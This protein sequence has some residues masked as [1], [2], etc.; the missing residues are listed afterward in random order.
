MSEQPATSGRGRGG[1]SNRRSANKG[2]G[3]G[4]R[5]GGRGGTP[6][7]KKENNVDGVAVAEKIQNLTVSDKQ[8]TKGGRG[9]G[10]GRGGGGSKSNS[11][12]RKRVPANSKDK[13]MSEDEI[14]RQQDEVK[15]REQKVIEEAERKRLEEE[16][17][18]DEAMKAAKQKQR[19]DLLQKVQD[20]IVSLESVVTT[21]LAHKKNRENLCAENLVKA[22]CEFEQAK[23]SLKSDLKK[24]TAFVKKVKTGAAWS[25]KPSDVE[26]DIG[27]L[28]LS[29]YVEEVA[30]AVLEAKL[31]LGDLPVVIELCVAMHTRYADFLPN[32]VPNMWIIIH[33]KPTEETAKLRRIYVRLMT[34]FLLNGI[35][36]ETKQLLKLVGE[37][38]GGSAGTYAVSDA[39][40]MVSF[41]KAAA[42]E[43]LGG[44]P[45]SIRQEATILATELRKLETVERDEIPIIITDELAARAKATLDAVDEVLQLRAV[46][47][48]ITEVFSAHCTGA[49]QSL[50]KSLVT[51]HAKLQKLEKRCDQDR[52]LQGS[53]SD[54][55]DK[56][57]ADA[58]KLQ[59]SLLKSVETLSD[60]LD[61]VAPVL[62]DEK[63]EEHEVGQ[64]IELW[65]K[66]D[67]GGDD[68]LGP[69]D[70]EET[71][72]F[73]CDISDLLATVPPAL[74]GMTE[75]E[76][77]RIK[78]ENLVKYGDDAAQYMDDS[79]TEVE[80]TSEDQF[81]EEEE[82]VEQQNNEGNRDT[83]DLEK[84]KDNPHYRLMVLLEQELPECS[85]REQ[86][87]EISE[88]FCVN[89]GCSKNSRKRLVKTLFQ[90]PRSR[91]DLLPYYS[92]MLAILDRVY[93][94]IAA[95]VVTDLEQQFHGQAKFKKNQNLEGRL[96]T[97]RYIGELTKFRVAPPIVSL[98][99]FRRCLDDFTG[100]NI[101]VACCILE[102]CGRYLYRT[103]HTVSN[104]SQLMDAMMRIAQSKVS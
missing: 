60:V 2:G 66:G 11:N 71:R 43:V 8:P 82:A 22:R 96:K 86:I 101:D 16:Q 30:A 81:L 36:Y 29:R 77:E 63:E 17:K 68:N 37:V 45:R 57:L 100:F 69:F 70:D 78:A 25:M 50:A 83:E 23:K 80:P 48:E 74:L 99:C 102:S 59:E 54:A 64:G 28:N 18:A 15:L 55:R 39:N 40:L 10:E 12:R 91:L 42:F 27:S 61:Q 9:G 5:G 31:K 67:E 20:T 32:L 88:K 24:C 87:D 72:S 14:Q 79:V 51:T 92:R 34:E 1:G 89:H 13:P 3:R 7:I 73:Y 95:P 52:L 85:R 19:Q 6:Q 90:V 94:D 53:L 35:I 58:R 26:K 104:L 46:Q 76:I 33:S 4:G 103:K 65:T 98:R 75:R 41:C 84:D 38:T 93:S 21:T 47:P 44:K 56:G 62:V 97:A 49:Y